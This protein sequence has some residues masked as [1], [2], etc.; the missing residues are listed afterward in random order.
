[1]DIRADEISQILKQQ[2][3]DFESR[4]TVSETGTI[5]SVGDGIARIHGLE[6]AVAGELLEFPGG[7]KGMVLNLEEDNVGAALFGSDQ[8]VHEGDEVKR[9][10]KIV[11]VP[12]G[13]G[14]M[15]RVVDAIGN[16][17]DGLGPIV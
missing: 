3:K 2:I 7:L 12:V 16:P 8:G 1:M 11:E 5:L 15:G 4:V 6:N 13:P 17:V 9:T 14:L 10:G